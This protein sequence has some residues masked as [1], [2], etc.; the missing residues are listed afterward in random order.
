MY[1][2]MH[3]GFTEYGEIGQN[4]KKISSQDGVNISF[5]VATQQEYL[6]IQKM[7]TFSFSLNKLF[8]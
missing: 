7:I 8:K 6:Q 4:R 5:F 3:V 2:H 1:A